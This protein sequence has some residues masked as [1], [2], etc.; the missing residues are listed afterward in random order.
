M[1]RQSISSPL[2]MIVM[3]PTIV[4]RFS[5]K[6]CSS[7]RRARARPPGP[8][9][10]GRS[11]LSVEGVL[12][13]A[14]DRVLGLVEHTAE[15]LVFSGSI[16]SLIVLA[17]S[18]VCM[19]CLAW[20]RLKSSRSRLFQIVESPISRMLDALLVPDGG[21]ALGRCVEGDGQRLEVAAILLGRKIHVPH[22]FDGAGRGRRIISL[23]GTAGS[24]RCEKHQCSEMC[25][26]V[27]HVLSLPQGVHRSVPRTDHHR[28][29]GTRACGGR[30]SRHPLRRRDQGEAR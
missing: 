5:A 9:G 19:N 7:S 17:C 14:R 29:Q 8:R 13:G 2:S 28:C 16:R 18:I 27:P 30:R 22:T 15:A 26:C 11:L 10:S 24:E 23:Q 20:F 1:R 6:M 12:L 21:V 25:E 4:P 3:L